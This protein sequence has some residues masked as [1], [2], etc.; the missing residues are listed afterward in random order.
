V[1]YKAYKGQEAQRD[2][3]A[4]QARAQTDAELAK[5]LSPAEFT[6]LEAWRKK[7]KDPYTR[8]FFGR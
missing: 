1:I 2:I 6:A 3:K 7:S 8:G 4:N 5:V